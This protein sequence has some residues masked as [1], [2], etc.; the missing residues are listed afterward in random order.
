MLVA[1]PSIMHTG[2]H[3]F[4]NYIFKD[5]ESYPGY[6]KEG[7]DYAYKIHYITQARPV[8]DEVLEKADYIVSPMRHPARVLQSFIRRN[9]SLDMNDYLKIPFVVRKSIYGAMTGDDYET[10]WRTLAYFM[11]KYNIKFI[12]VDDFSGRD[13]QVQEVSKIIC[14]PLSCEWPVDRTSGSSC[15]THNY[16]FTTEDLEKVPAWILD[17]YN[18]TLG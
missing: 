3:L 15:N 8:L 10:Q 7:V 5:F 11:G 1:T 4:E 2:T 13:E 18:E 9:R 12:H 17:L 16:E 14:K 6:S